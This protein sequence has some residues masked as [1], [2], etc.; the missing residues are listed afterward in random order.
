MANVPYREL[1]GIFGIIGSGKSYVAKLIA[2]KREYRYVNVDE[3]IKNSI[4]TNESHQ[5][6]L[7]DFFKIFD[8]SFFTD[9][10]RTKVNSQIVSELLFSEA[11]RNLSFPILRSFNKLNE[12]Y[13]ADI[14][15]EEIYG[16]A[17]CIVDMALLPMYQSIVPMNANI[18]VRGDAFED[19][20]K[21][22]SNHFDR[23]VNR[24]KRDINVTANIIR[25]QTNKLMEYETH[26]KSFKLDNMDI[27][28]G[29]F[30]P[31]DEILRQFD[32]IVMSARALTHVGLKYSDMFS[33]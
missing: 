2:E 7:I 19:D 22:C 20:I 18:L 10:T 1:I 23:I 33:Y 16:S 11:Q 21:H 30:F 26:N 29:G 6:R 17:D 27:K 5:V 8:I 31:D 24:D 15:R 13:F 28:N 25:Y 9:D 14:V 3:L 4:M 32:D 12:T